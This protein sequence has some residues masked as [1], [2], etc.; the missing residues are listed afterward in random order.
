[1][2]RRAAAAACRRLALLLAFAAVVAIG[3]V[4][5]ATINALRWLLRPPL[6][7]LHSRLGRI[8]AVL[9]LALLV[10]SCHPPRTAAHLAGTFAGEQAAETAVRFR[11]ACRVLPAG[12]LCQ[13][14]GDS[15][16]LEE[17]WWRVLD[18]RGAMLAWAHGCRD[19]VLNLPAG[20]RRLEVLLPAVVAGRQGWRLA[21]VKEVVR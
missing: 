21:Y 20:A 11:L 13:A 12:L 8:L 5:G 4:L 15:P 19:V 14:T 9:L 17:L 18:A 16:L 7:A 6:A 1:M 2:T 3:A 10:T